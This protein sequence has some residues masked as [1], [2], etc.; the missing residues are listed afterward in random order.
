MIDTCLKTDN[1]K[2]LNGLRRHYQWMKKKLS[3]LLQT[4]REGFQ[5]WDWISH[6]SRTSFINN[7]IPE[8][9][10]NKNTGMRTLLCIQIQNNGHLF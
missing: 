6:L 5:T 8:N 1:G 7:D 9:N 10:N 2:E 3:C 4:F